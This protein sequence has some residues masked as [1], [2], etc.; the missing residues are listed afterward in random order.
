MSTVLLVGAFGQG[1]PGDEALCGAF[2]H[3]LAGHDVIV[4][5]AD[6]DGTARRFGVRTIPA[7]PVATLR[8][9]RSADALVVGGGTIFKTLHT[10]TGRWRTSLLRDASA[11]TA[12]ARASG[13]KVAMVGVG[14]AELRGRWARSLSRW[15]VRHA[16]LLVLRDEESA[17]VLADAGVPTPFWIG[18]DPV[19]ALVDD[20]APVAVRPR[21]ASVT[22][23]LSHLAGDDRFVGNLATAVG[24]LRDRYSVRLQPWQAGAG[25]R[26][27]ELARSLRRRLGSGVEIVDPPADMASAAASL[28]GDA[29]LIGL[30]FHALIAAAIAET[31]FVAVAHEP[32]LAGLSRRLGQVSVPSHATSAVMAAAVA[33]AFDHDPPTSAAVQAEV[34]AARRS[35][36]LMGLLLSGG[37]SE[38]PHA[39]AGLPLSSGAATG[40]R[41][42]LDPRTPDRPRVGRPYGAAPADRDGGPDRGR[43]R[44]PAV[45]RRARPCPRPRRVRQGRRVPR[46]LRAA[47]PPRRRLERGGRPRT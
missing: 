32:K 45:R 16:D 13:A 47:Q 43:D 11:L 10:S 37:S 26:D 20:T 35:F 27:H 23:A 34:L 1:N 2:C 42:R 6:P 33:H 4:A 44:Q 7:D 38:E 21:D 8:A 15:L 24:P 5:T 18:A 12:A 19:W 36:D 14:A 30:R 3:A 39:V 9:A 40:E 28:A 46:P 41:R 31:R 25:G 17:A 22:V 29:L